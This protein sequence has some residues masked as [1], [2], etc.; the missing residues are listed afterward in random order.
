MVCCAV[1]T[2]KSVVYSASRPISDGATGWT[3]G[4]LSREWTPLTTARGSDARRAECA[5]LPRSRHERDR[6]LG[7]AGGQ[8]Y[9]LAGACLAPRSPTQPNCTK[10]S[11]SSFILDLSEVAG[12]E[13]KQKRFCLHEPPASSSSR[14]EGG[15]GRRPH[16]SVR[17]RH[18][19]RP[20][21]TASIPSAPGR[22][23][24]RPRPEDRLVRRVLVVIDE[25]ARSSFHQAEVISSG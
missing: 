1:L 17:N 6:R 20:S 14:L 4:D 13:W 18:R 12:P 3:V 24:H 21:G 22:A 11:I 2:L 23:L 8:E 9:Q 7:T 5:R 19:A 16:G 25:D 15:C 10:E